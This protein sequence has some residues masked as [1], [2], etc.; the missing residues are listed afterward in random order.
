MLDLGELLDRDKAGTQ[1]QLPGGHAGT[2]QALHGGGLARRFG[3]VGRIND[4]DVHGSR[5][6]VLHEAE[7]PAHH[8]DVLRRHVVS[9]R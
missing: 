8:L 9:V 1:H 2:E 6:H 7:G 4:P 3:D 5:G